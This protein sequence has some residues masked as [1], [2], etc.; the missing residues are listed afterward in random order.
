M[1]KRNGFTLIELLVVI[2]II[3]ILA[4]IL[5]PVFA[6]AREKARQISCVNNLKQLG[7]A[8]IQYT[9]DNDEMLPDKG[10]PCSNAT[11]YPDCSNGNKNW[12]LLIY[13]FVK[14][15]GVYVC[16]SN[17]NNGTSSN[18]VNVPGSAD[19]MCNFWKTDTTGA[20][21]GAFTDYAK[22]GL[23]IAQIAAPASLIML[24]E[25]PGD[26]I[27][28]EGFP[29][30]NGS[31]DNGWDFNVND[32]RGGG[33]T[34]FGPYAGHTGVSNFVFADGHVKS[35]RPFATVTATA[36]G[37]S[38]INMWSYDNSDFDAT[39]AANVKQSFAAGAANFQ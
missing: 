19:Y 7:L 35:L 29:G 14:S 20:S 30:S 24:V 16:P 6:Q 22:S 25:N 5:F 33:G 3:A 15:A 23:N 37:S 13:P 8:I 27:D 11:A 32:R 2:A 1:L 9:Q 28:I 26:T 17:P 31:N 4:A 38:P 36:G 21:M 18:G 10:G 12:E 39:D 34:E